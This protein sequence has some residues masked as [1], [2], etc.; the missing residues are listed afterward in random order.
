MS[1]TGYLAVLNA[2]PSLEHPSEKVSG[3]PFALAHE[4]QIKKNIRVRS[5]SHEVI[6]T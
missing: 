6:D 1:Q 5:V 3:E 4:I 2:A